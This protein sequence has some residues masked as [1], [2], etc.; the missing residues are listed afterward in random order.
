MSENIDAQSPASHC[1][2]RA[3]CLEDDD[4]DLID[5]VW[6]DIM[7][8]ISSSEKEDAEATREPTRKTRRQ[9]PRYLSCFW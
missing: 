2:E 6:G 8:A 4:E 9:R 5:A 7:G 3:Y 1:V